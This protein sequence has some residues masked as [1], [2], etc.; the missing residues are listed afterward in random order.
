MRAYVCACVCVYILK[1]IADRLHELPVIQTGP[2][3]E[4]GE[5]GAYKI[6]KLTTSLMALPILTGQSYFRFI[7]GLVF[8]LSGMFGSLTTPERKLN[9]SSHPIDEHQHPSCLLQRG[10]DRIDLTTDE[11][12]IPSPITMWV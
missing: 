10:C 4:R 9:D 2:V 3:R 7:S 6:A 5:L 8:C 11:H 1:E 12:S